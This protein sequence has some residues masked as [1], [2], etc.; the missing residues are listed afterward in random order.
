[1]SSADLDLFF[2]HL[3]DPVYQERDLYQNLYHK[4]Q[5][6][7]LLQSETL[8]HLRSTSKVLN[9]GQYNSDI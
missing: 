1:M 5:P 2:L 8:K 3:K 7:D 4:C 6:S 9:R